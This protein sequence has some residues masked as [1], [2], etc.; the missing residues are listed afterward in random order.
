[1][2]EFVEPYARK[3]KRQLPIAQRKTSPY[4]EIYTEEQF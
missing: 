3:A 2:R 1:M 4:I